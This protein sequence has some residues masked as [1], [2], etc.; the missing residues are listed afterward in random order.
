MPESL[1][2]CRQRYDK[3]KR[4]LKKQTPTE[5]PSVTGSSLSIPP[6]ASSQIGPVVTPTP[7]ISSEPASN[8]VKAYEFVHVDLPSV[9][10]PPEAPLNP[11]DKQK[12]K[13]LIQEDSLRGESQPLPET[14]ASLT[15]SQQTETGFPL[16]EMGPQVAGAGPIAIEKRR[17]RPR[18]KVLPRTESHNTEQVQLDTGELGTI[19]PPS[20]AATPDQTHP[21]PLHGG[22]KRKAVNTVAGDS[23]T[24]K[25]TRTTRSQTKSAA[26]LTEGT[27]PPPS[28]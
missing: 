4:A 21:G 8:I 10:T 28:R 5:G 3:L 7:T 26:A 19:I 1:L 27:P 22:R 16:S 20:S 14:L 24:A 23:S 12:E 13:E 17:P 6:V 11:R 2:Q 25:K 18:P 15:T 9:T